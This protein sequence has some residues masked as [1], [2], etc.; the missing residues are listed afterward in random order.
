MTLNAEIEH[1]SENELERICMSYYLKQWAYQK[2]ECAA[3]QNDENIYRKWSRYKQYNV[4]NKHSHSHQAIEKCIGNEGGIWQRER[5]SSSP[6]LGEKNRNFFGEDMPL[7]PNLI[8]IKAKP[9]KIFRGQGSLR[10]VPTAQTTAL[11]LLCQHLFAFAW[12]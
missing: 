10:E 8:N 12:L 9:A 1:L 4:G 7:Y 6:Y 2:R 11:K 3:L 5:K